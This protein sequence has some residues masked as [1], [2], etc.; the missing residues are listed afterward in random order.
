MSETP[1]AETADR[2]F[3]AM[4]KPH[5][6]ACNLE[7]EYC[8][9]LEKADLYPER[10]GVGMSGDTLETLSASTSRPSPARR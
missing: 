2:P 1:P 4:T 9:Y 10:N 7:C 3:H 6:P 8:F 5:G